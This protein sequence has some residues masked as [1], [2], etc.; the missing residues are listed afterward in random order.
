M[1]LA[2]LIVETANALQMDPLDLAT[3]ISFETSGTFNPTQRGPTTKWG[4]H[5][6]LI[7]WGEPQAQQ[8][9]VDWNDPIGSQL[10]ANGAIVRYFQ[11]RGWQPGMD[12][13]NA[14]SI[15][16]AGSPGRFN[17]SDTAAGGTWGTVRDKWTHQ[18]HDHRA[19]AAGLLGGSFV[20]PPGQGRLGGP[21]AAPPQQGDLSMGEAMP[22]LAGLFG[23][24]GPMN[25]LPQ[26]RQQDD[27]QE[28]TKRRRQALFGAGGLA[29]V[30]G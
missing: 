28:R 11:G 13:M 25:V 26:R 8:Y 6:G 15:V 9:G 24:A 3:I 18:M 30:Y 21:G 7:Q 12:G 22:G 16:N 14:Y 1:G 29:D 20:P 19:K 5:K 17:A 27:E 10:G 23:G 2:D 4:Q